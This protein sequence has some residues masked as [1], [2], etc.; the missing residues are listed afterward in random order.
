M[1]P[2]HPCRHLTS[3]GTSSALTHTKAV[4]YFI[5]NTRGKQDETNY[6]PCG[7]VVLIVPF[8]PLPPQASDILEAKPTVLMLWPAQVNPAACSTVE[9]AALMMP[10]SLSSDPTSYPLIILT[11]PSAQASSHLYQRTP[12]RMSAN[13]MPSKLFDIGY[14]LITSTHRYLFFIFFAPNTYALS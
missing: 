7:A 1:F 2:I 9:Q 10:G 11:T 14:H 3:W 8:R 13:P 12:V 4:R 5:A 6:A